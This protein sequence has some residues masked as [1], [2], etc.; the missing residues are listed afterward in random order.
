MWKLFSGIILAP[1]LPGYYCFF[2]IF[3]LR[4]GSE[5]Y[6]D[7]IPQPAWNLCLSYHTPHRCVIVLHLHI[8]HRSSWL[9]HAVLQFL[10]WHAFSGST[11]TQCSFWPSLYF[12]SKA[13]LPQHEAILLL[14]NPASSLSHSLMVWLTYSSLVTTTVHISLVLENQY[15]YTSIPQASHHRYI[16]CQWSVSNLLYDWQLVLHQIFHIDKL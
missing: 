1:Q 14:L 9:P 4:C 10:S 11:K 6:P 8:L 3:F 5:L 15:Q 7:V 16:I 13:P 2:R 12:S